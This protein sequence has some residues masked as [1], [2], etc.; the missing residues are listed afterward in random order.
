MNGILLSDDLL[1]SSRITATARA[2]QL[3]VT[4]AKTAD[5]LLAKARELPPTGVILDLNN[6]GLAVAELLVELRTL[7]P[8]NVVAYCS[9]VDVE[10]IQAAKQAGCDLVMPRS[11]F[12][13]KL[14]SD[15]PRWL[16]VTAST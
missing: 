6:P 16:T 9:H 1:F 5:K 15:I 10:R 3:A 8:V 7:G 13:A 14:E 11:Q 4:V 2:H 12:V